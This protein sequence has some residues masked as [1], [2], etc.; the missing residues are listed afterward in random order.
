MPKPFFTWPLSDLT[1]RIGNI[2]SALLTL[3][4]AQ[5]DA[6]LL[7]LESRAGA[8]ESAPVAVRAMLAMYEGEARRRMQRLAA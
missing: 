3:P 5:L 6:E 7:E 1:A 2:E 4:D 8:R